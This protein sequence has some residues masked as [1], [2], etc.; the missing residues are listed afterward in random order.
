VELETSVRHR[1]GFDATVS[2][3]FQ[4]A[5]N[6]AADDRLVNTPAHLFQL[7]ASTPVLHHRLRASLTTRHVSGQLLRD[8]SSALP[9]TLADLRIIGVL[10]DDRVSI[11]VDVTNLFNQDYG[12]P[13]GEEQVLR[14]IPQDARA[15]RVGARIGF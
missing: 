9:Y 7:R 1:A 4:I 10:P 14:L 15:L 5:R 11:E 6:P 8:G 13:G 2:Y 3:T 12:S